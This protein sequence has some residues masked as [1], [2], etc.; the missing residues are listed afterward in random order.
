MER[1]IKE[2][3]KETKNKRRGRQVRVGGWW[4][5]E[6]RRKNGDVRKKLKK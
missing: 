2:V 4:D 5:E 3:L 1:K 6:C